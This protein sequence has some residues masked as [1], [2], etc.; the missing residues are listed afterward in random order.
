MNSNL[1]I[2]KF[3]QITQIKRFYPRTKFFVSVNVLRMVLTYAAEK[4]LTAI[5][6]T[7]QEKIS[8]VISLSFQQGDNCNIA[9]ISLSEIIL[10]V[11]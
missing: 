6:S 8:K 1:I 5:K 9:C 10:S 2:Y 3:L 11:T 7:E 4:R